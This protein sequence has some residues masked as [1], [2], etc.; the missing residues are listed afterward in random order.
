MGGHVWLRPTFRDG[1]VLLRGGLSGP[2]R[3]RLERKTGDA[4][5]RR[6]SVSRLDENMI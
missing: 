5:R 6:L 3:A 2:L 4:S 1:S